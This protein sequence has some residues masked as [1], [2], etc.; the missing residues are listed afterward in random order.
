MTNDC[1]IAI[2]TEDETD[3]KVVRKIIHRVIDKSTKTKNWSSKGCGKLKRKLAAHLLE[4]SKA[5]YNIFITGR[6]A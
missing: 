5:G 4:L 1:S 3:Y 2:I 6:D